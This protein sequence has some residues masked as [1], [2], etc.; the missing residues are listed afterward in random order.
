VNV[1][2][3]DRRS[4]LALA[5][6]VL[7][8]LALRFA[9]RDDRQTS[10]VVA[11]DTIPRAERRLGVLRMAAAS[12]PGREEVLK[13]AR[14][15][16]ASREKG[17][18]TADTAAQAEARLIEIVRRVGKSAGMDV[19]GAEDLRVG[20]LSGDYG[21]VTVGVGFNCA[22]EQLV[23]FLA[24]LANEPALLATKEIRITSSSP[25]DKTIAVRLDLS[26]VV[27]R[28]LVPAKKGADSF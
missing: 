18:L 14:A 12:V 13:R 22:I 19:R 21:E 2:K 6:G 17:L 5:L 10:V 15:E 27:P 8:V 11:D 7:A 20:P 24:G 1:G 23:N 26:A 3:L 4:G 28:R 9:F 16:L 25:K